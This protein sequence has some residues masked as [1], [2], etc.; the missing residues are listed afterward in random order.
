MGIG[1]STMLLVNVGM[2]KLNV[3]VTL[4]GLFVNLTQPML[5]EVDMGQVLVGCGTVRLIPRWDGR[6]RM[7]PP[8]SGA[9]G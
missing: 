2:W 7:G 5:Q 4:C 9:P 3:G 1:R 8:S 6:V